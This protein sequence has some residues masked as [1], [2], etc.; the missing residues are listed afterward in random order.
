[1]S[2]FIFCTI[3]NKQFLLNSVLIWALIVPNFNT[4]GW[5]ISFDGDI[6]DVV[7]DDS[8]Q[9]IVVDSVVGVLEDTVVGSNSGERLWEEEYLVRGA[10]G[11]C[12]EG[13]PVV[14]E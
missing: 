10:A 12:S 2:I 14:V 13:N 11:G 7:D 8:R 9:D 5:G 4:V 6:A 1:M 3:P